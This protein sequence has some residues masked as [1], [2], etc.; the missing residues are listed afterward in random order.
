MHTSLFASSL[1]S[2]ALTAASFATVTPTTLFGD[3]YLVSD[4][5]RTYSVL[6]VYIKGSSANDIISSTFGTSGWTSSYTMNQ[7]DVFVHS[8]SNGA[9][10]AWLPASGQTSWDSFVT[11]GNRDQA[12]AAGFLQMQLDSNWAAGNG[13]AINGSAGTG[14]AGWYPAAGAS[15]NSNPYCR[16]GYY[17]DSG[18]T[19]SPIN[20]AK[21]ESDIAGNGISVG[22]SLSN[23][24][25]IGRFTIEVTGL[26]ASTVKTM[27]MKF[28]IAGKQNGTTTFTGATSAA[29]RFDHTLTFAVPAPGAA[30][31]LAL[32]GI[33]GRRRRTNN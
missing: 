12:S 2:L 30:A 18:I 33:G 17:N 27:T 15:T 20:R 25:M 19:I 14:G 11:T 9:N 26:D 29:G 7:G 22:Q 1:A 13:G 5:A 32:A 28:A 23:H 21:A 16:I 6:D 8:N 24:W 31:L 4:G 10:T 3:S